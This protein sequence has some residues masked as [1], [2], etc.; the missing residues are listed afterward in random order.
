MARCCWVCAQPGRGGWGACLQATVGEPAAGPARKPQL[1]GA[2]H[3]WNTLP[4]APAAFWLR[5]KGSGESG[6]PSLAGAW[7]PGDGW[8]F[9]LII[10]CL[11]CTSST[12]GRAF[13][14]S[15]AKHRR[16]R[17]AG[18]QRKARS[19]LQTLKAPQDCFAKGPGYPWLQTPPTLR[20]FPPPTPTSSP[21]SSTFAPEAAVQRIQGL[22]GSKRGQAAW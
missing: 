6:R 8:V 22:A 15:L 16:W 3:T 11:E 12:I 21:L 5:E 2:D 1:G 7:E 20:R 9:S 17:D 10:E 13:F 18:F 14:A 4:A 19:A